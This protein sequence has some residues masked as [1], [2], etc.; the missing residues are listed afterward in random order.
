MLY[1]YYITYV[2]TSNYHRKILSFIIF[3]LGVKISVLALASLP[4]NSKEAIH[5]GFCYLKDELK[6]QIQVP[7][8]AK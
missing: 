7:N 2:E 5:K 6:K 4:E 8:Q 1:N 3:H